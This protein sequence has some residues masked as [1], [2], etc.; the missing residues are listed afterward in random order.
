MNSTIF[1]FPR[2]RPPYL[3]APDQGNTLAEAT[4]S[5]S[6]K[7]APSRKTNMQLKILALEERTL[8][9]W[10]HRSCS[11]EIVKSSVAQMKVLVEGERRKR[12][13]PCCISGTVTIYM[14]VTKTL[15]RSAQSRQ[16]MHCIE[17]VSVGTTEMNWKQ[18]LQKFTKSLILLKECV[19]AWIRSA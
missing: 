10:L 8:E 17:K 19:S 7:Y 2:W 1:L 18:Q 9:N 12:V 13:D 14:L 16:K 6:E 4:K 11:K 15:Q 5:S 3:R